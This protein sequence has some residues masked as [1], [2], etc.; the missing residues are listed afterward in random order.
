MDDGRISVLVRQCLDKIGRKVG[1][2]G[3]EEL[4]GQ[5]AH[6]RRR[7]DEKGLTG[8]VIIDRQEDGD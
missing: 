7:R 3:G 2:E 8:L 6:I 1:R 4:S 5:M